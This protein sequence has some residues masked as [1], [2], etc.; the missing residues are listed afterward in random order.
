MTRI[1]ITDQQILNVFD[2]WIMPDAACK[3]LYTTH[4]REAL[5]VADHTKIY[6]VYDVRQK[7]KNMAVRGIL[8]ERPQGKNCTA[9]ALSDEPK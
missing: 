5:S 7:L 2:R 1:I 8:E 4:I 9:W 6:P 3:Q